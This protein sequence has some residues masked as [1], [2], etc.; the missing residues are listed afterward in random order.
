MCNNGYLLLKENIIMRDCVWQILS[1]N[2]EMEINLNFL[3][4]TD[5]FIWKIEFFK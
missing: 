2:L 1:S 3:D 5:N 4:R